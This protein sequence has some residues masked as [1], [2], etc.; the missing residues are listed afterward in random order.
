MCRTFGMLGLVAA[1]FAVSA[2]TPTPSGRRGGGDREDSD[3][4]EGSMAD[5]DTGGAGDT[6]GARDS[7]SDTG[8]ADP[9]PQTP[10]IVTVDHVTCTQQQSAGQVWD[11]SLQV[12]DPQGASTVRRGTAQVLDAAENV[13]VP[14]VPLACG[15]G[16]CVGSMRADLTGVPCGTAT[17]WRFVVTDTDGNESE[18][19]RFAP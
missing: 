12:D 2:C 13:L 7:S 3:T 1:G 16:T 8:A 19:F 15:N 18:P 17:V 4:G 6:G 14:E 11:V 10:S 5:P 9:G